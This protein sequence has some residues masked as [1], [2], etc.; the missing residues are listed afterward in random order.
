MMP[1]LSV[2]GFLGG[3][4]VTAMEGGRFDSPFPLAVY[5][6]SWKALTSFLASADLTSVGS[7]WCLPLPTLVPWLRR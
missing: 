7:L 5:W 6:L 3:Y 1:F 4:S 2:G